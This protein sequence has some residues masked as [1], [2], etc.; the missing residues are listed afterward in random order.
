M[1]NSS[2][3]NVIVTLG[4]GPEEIIRNART[5]NILFS[6][7]IKIQLDLLYFN[8]CSTRYPFTGKHYFTHDPAPYNKIKTQAMT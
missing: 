3:F 5:L 8:S 7:K 4:Y 1:L 6:S 2:N